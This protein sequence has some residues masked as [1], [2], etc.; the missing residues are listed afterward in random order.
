MYHVHV[1][2][3]M[4]EWVVRVCVW[5]RVGVVRVWMVV[6]VLMMDDRMGVVG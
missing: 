4:G 5:V 3:G 1:R 6:R 2:V